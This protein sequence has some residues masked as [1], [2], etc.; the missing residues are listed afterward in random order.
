MVY[1][2]YL[3]KLYFLEPIMHKNL[4]WGTYFKSQKRGY[5]LRFGK[6]PLQKRQALN[7]KL[8]KFLLEPLKDIIKD[9]PHWI[10]S[11][12]GALASIPF[13]TLRLDEQP[14]IAQHHI[15]Y[16]QSLSISALLKK[17]DQ[18]YKNIQDRSTLLAMGAPLYESS[19]TSKGKP[20]TTDYNIARQMIR[21]GGDYA[22][23]FSQ[24]DL[25][26]LDLQNNMI[27]TDYRCCKNRVHL[28][29]FW[30]RKREFQE[31]LQSVDRRKE[32]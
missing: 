15:S 30:M 10:I 19:A 21:R 23:A 22:S 12:S 16:V 20:S 5:S 24:L 11:P 9:K 18:V 2:F 28:N 1:K 31:F 27:P 29:V 32:L 14:A 3:K 17:R 6:T 7:K 26:Q 8:T 4:W 13:E 25:N